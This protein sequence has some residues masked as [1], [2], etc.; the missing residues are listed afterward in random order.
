MNISMLQLKSENAKA[1]HTVD[2]ATLQQNDGQVM[3]RDTGKTV[4]GKVEVLEAH[5]RRGLM[6][7]LPSASKD[8][9]VLIYSCKRV[10][11]GGGGDIEGARGCEKHQSIL[12]TQN[13]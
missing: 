4:N 11:K 10:D 2:Y 1:G 12:A 5:S 8:T 7:A 3:Y 6:N 13:F 9:N